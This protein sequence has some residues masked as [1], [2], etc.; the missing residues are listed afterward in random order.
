MERE[1]DPVDP[2]RPDHSAG[3]QQ[4]ES[5]FGEGQEDTQKTPAE[6]VLPDFARGVDEEPDPAAEEVIGRFSDNV[7]AAPETVE[8]N[9]EGSFAS[10]QETHPEDR[11]ESA[12][13]TAA[14]R[15]AAGEETATGNLARGTDA[16][17]ERD[18]GSV[19]AERARGDEPLR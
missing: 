2:G 3:P 14:V 6:E 12:E 5:G 15:E 9:L 7:D 16:V 18:P 19:Q 17:G 10:G 8:K 1:N 11:Y 4:T 13:Q